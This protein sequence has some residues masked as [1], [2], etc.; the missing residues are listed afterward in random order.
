MGIDAPEL[1]WAAFVDDREERAFRLRNLD[2]MRRQ[3]T[4]TIIVTLLVSWMTVRNDFLLESSRTT[5]AL[6]IA[7]RVAH[8]LFSVGVCIIARRARTPE[9]ILRATSAWLMA[10]V[11]AKFLILTTRPADFYAHL[12]GDVAFLLIAPLA[13][14]IPYT[15]QIAAMA[16]FA[17][18]DGLIA[19]VFR[20]TVDEATATARLMTYGFAF[21]IAAL[22]AYR[23]Q[24]WMRREFHALRSET[25]LRESLTRAL[26]EVR[27]LR[28]IVPICAGCH[29]IRDDEG[30]WHTVETYVHEH[31]HADFSH[32]L[33]PTCV[34][35]LYPGIA[36]EVLRDEQERNEQERIEPRAGSG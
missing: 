29:G 4:L 9:P 7:L 6:L 17:I 25:A 2:D 33:C 18:S 19:V 11:I 20:N 23:L 14:P 10:T 27:T 8:T 1:R 30:Y 24:V 21:A 3:A 34:R 5:T 22:T 28:G 35:R 12:P 15:R 13:L 36:D 32:G 16:A 31:T 26:S